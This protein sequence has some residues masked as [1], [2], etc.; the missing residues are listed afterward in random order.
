MAITAT[1]LA[2][3]ICVKACYSWGKREQHAWDMG[4]PTIGLHGML[5]ELKK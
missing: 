2:C 1:I 3:A 5:V 4:R